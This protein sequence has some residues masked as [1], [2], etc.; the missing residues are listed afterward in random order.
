MLVILSRTTVTQASEPR[1]NA[2]AVFSAPDKEDSPG[3]A[4][5]LARHGNIVYERAYPMANLHYNLPMI[6]KSHFFVA[7]RSKQ[8]TAFCSHSRKSRNKT[9]GGIHLIAIAEDPRYAVG[10][11]LDG[12]EPES[13]ITLDGWCFSRQSMLE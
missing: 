11:E 7:S 8:F 4:L 6:P 9:S 10:S 13:Q 12:C 3:C 5:A 1:S 2:E